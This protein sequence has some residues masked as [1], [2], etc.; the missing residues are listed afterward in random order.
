L[1]YAH[2]TEKGGRGISKREAY[3][4]GSPGSSPQ[5][6]EGTKGRILN[7]YT[8]AI[9][10]G[11]FEKEKKGC[12]RERVTGKCSRQIKCNRRNTTSSLEGRKEQG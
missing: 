10:T 12:L 2:E 4:M 8:P 1:V 9:T 7:P 5:N 6:G 3:T 11:K